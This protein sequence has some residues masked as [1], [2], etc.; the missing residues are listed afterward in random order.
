[1]TVL[2]KEKKTETHPR[3]EKTLT[4]ELS[5]FLECLVDLWGDILEFD[6]CGVFL[7]G[8][9]NR[10]MVPLIWVHPCEDYQKKLK[11]EWIR[12]IRDQL[13]GE[14]KVY[15]LRDLSDD[16][17]SLIFA[18]FKT[19]QKDGVFL[20]WSAKPK[21]SFT[22]KELEMISFLAE[23]LNLYAESLCLQEKLMRL[24]AW[25]QESGEYLQ[26]IGK[27]AAVGELTAGA[28]HEINNPLQIILGK[29]Q[30]LMMRLSRLSG[31]SKHID[32][33]QV[34]EK[35]ATRISALINELTGFARGQ[36]EDDGLNSDVNIKQALRL[37]GS[38]VKN[39][40]EAANI[41]LLV[42]IE[43]NLP[44]VKGNINQIE[45]LLLNL[46]LNAKS[47]MSGGGR[48]EIEAKRDGNWVALRFRDNRQA[49]PAEV[50]S[51]LFEPF[52]CSG[53]NKG[54]GLG[55]YACHQIAKRHKGEIEVT[56][57]QDKGTVFWV[58]LPVI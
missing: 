50:L 29:T 58:R 47:S 23:Q 14:K 11:G 20:I 36:G 32:A 52:A 6:N 3:Q 9:E 43:N 1:M 26:Q 22:A 21:E 57:D 30:L 34:I 49:I 40:L 42:K 27:L 37:V 24:S 45:Q 54:L 19:D 41:K 25:I 17:R 55:L 5:R 31:N 2:S 8:D 10:N 16:R 51:R 18:P 13:S 15:L 33:L 28:A 39:R 7:W 35:N 53:G 38:L 56:S 46:I 44:A 4:S 12:Q 48:L